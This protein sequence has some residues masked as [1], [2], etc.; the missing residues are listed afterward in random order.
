MVPLGRGVNGTRRVSVR[1][2]SRI[3]HNNNWRK[4]CLGLLTTTSWSFWLGDAKPV[5][6]VSIVL[7][8]EKRRQHPVGSP[9]EVSAR[10]I[11]FG[12]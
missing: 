6:S 3:G 1:Y 5:V 11:G 2:F 7:V 10:K 8:K 12:T 4:E 9:A